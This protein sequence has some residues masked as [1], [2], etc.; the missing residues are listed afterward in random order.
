MTT[1]F[2]VWICISC[3]LGL[4]KPALWA[5]FSPRWVT[6][7]LAI[8]MLAMGTTLTIE[9]FAAVAKSPGNV[10]LGAVLQYTIMPGKPPGQAAY[11]RSIPHNVLAVWPLPCSICMV[12]CCPGGTA[13]N[14]VTFLANAD[15]ALSVMM[16]TASTLAAV[17]MTPLLTQLLVGALVP[18]DGRGLF[19]STLQVVLAPVVLG[20]VLNQKAPRLVRFTAPFAPLVAVSMV[21]LVVASVMSQNAAAVKCAG[22]QLLGA[23]VALHTGGFALGYLVSKA[24]GVPERSART[25]SIEVG[26]QNSALGAVLASLHFSDPKTAVP[27]AIS[28]CLHSILGSVLAAFWRWKDNRAESQG[29]A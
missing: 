19:I 14:V 18:V 16:T 9:D 6:W 1:F 2:P 22:P 27:C 26:M 17:V 8:T 20:A 28:A 23:V 4:W 24:L 10:V 5:W 3:L 12:A 29:E 7:A 13:S 11:L 21:V 25:N 15:V